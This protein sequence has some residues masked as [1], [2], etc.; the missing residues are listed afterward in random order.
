V[1]EAFSAAHPE[2]RPEAVGTPVTS[3]AAAAVPVTA[4]MTLWPHEIN[5]NG[6]FIAAWKRTG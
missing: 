1:A 6:M 3:G 2:F 5:A 4:G